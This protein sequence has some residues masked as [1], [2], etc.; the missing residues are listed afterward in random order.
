MITCVIFCK[1]ETDIWLLPISA[2]G[3]EA[4]RRIWRYQDAEAH[5][6]QLLNQFE[7][8]KTTSIATSE[9][10]GWCFRLDGIT[11]AR[12]DQLLA[13]VVTTNSPIV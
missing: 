6:L 7:P 5:L 13:D 2:E 9:S 11:A 8:E 12:P 10:V 3:S 4:L 1:R